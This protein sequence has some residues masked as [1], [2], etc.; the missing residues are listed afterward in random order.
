MIE[1]VDTYY[2]WQSTPTLNQITRFYTVYGVYVP[3]RTVRA[4]IALSAFSQGVDFDR[5]GVGGAGA[6]IKR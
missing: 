2:L 4:T 5:G 6:Y 3:N 1:Y